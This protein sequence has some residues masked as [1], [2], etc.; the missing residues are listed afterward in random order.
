MVNRIKLVKLT[1]WDDMG[2]RETG[3]VHINS[4]DFSSVYRPT[5]SNVTTVKTVTGLWHVKETPEEII[6]MI[7][8]KRYG[9]QT[10]A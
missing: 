8:G 10:T 9:E 7:N 4:A 5:R 3:I 2:N 1:V 6:A